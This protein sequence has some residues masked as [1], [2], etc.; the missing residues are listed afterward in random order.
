M[1]L[2]AKY[3]DWALITGAS[4]GIGMAYARALAKQRI[5]LILVARRRNRLETLALGLQSRHRI[6]VVTIV[7]DLS[8]DDFIEKIM[9]RVSD[10][11]IGMLIHS[12]GFGNSQFFHQANLKKEADM[13][14]VNCL[15]LVRLTRYL[16]RPMVRRRRGAVIFVSSIAA[17]QPMPKMATYAAT[18][19]FVQALGEGLAFEL[20]RSGV[21]VLTVQPGL[22]ATEFQKKSGLKKVSH[23]IYARSPEQVVATSMAHLG[24]KQVVVDGWLNKVTVWGARIGP[25]NYVKRIAYLWVRVFGEI[26]FKG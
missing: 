4:S 8:K 5:N 3:G 23:T 22:T 26:R 14:R 10:K 19:A 7:A 12:A 6:Q 9:R 25:R 15:A 24:K 20:K 13:V 1:K 16:V 17:A 21:D 2:K 18:K 11:N